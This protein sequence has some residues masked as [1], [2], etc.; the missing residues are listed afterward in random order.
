MTI[1]K[2]V[3]QFYKFLFLWS[4]LV[5]KNRVSFNHTTFHSWYYYTK[6]QFRRCILNLK[7]T[8]SS[9]LVVSFVLVACLRGS[10]VSATLLQQPRRLITYIFNDLFCVRVFLSKI[11]SSS[12]CSTSMIWQEEAQISNLPLLKHWKMLLVLSHISH[13]FLFLGCKAE[14]MVAAVWQCLIPQVVSPKQRVSP[15]TQT[16]P[17]SRI[18]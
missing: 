2:L 17:L 18:M 1:V 11:S 10:W 15:Q 6:L 8:L 7:I 16:I 3:T 9:N 12:F 5:E 13:V 14:M 4:I